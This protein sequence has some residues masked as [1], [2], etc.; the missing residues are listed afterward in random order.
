MNMRSYVLLLV[1]LLFTRQYECRA[2]F[3]VIQGADTTAAL[4]AGSTINRGN[5]LH[6]VKLLQR[7][8]ALV[9]PAFRNRERSDESRAGLSIWSF[10]LSLLGSSVLPLSA[11]F[12]FAGAGAFVI[13]AAALLAVIAALVLGIMALSRGQRLKGLAIAGI[14]LS[15]YT[16][17]EALLVLIFILSFI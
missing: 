16:L 10:C 8:Q 5:V 13:G 7:A 12:L 1:L 17:L 15:G 4:P 14:A 6:P 9:H 11:V 3:V 2:A